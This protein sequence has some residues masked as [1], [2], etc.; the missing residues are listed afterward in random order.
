M[1]LSA[2]EANLLTGSIALGT[3]RVS[4]QVSGVLAAFEPT[5]LGE[6]AQ[7][8]LMDRAELKYLLPQAMLPSILAELRHSYRALTITG[9]PVGRYRTLYFDTPDM[10]LYMRHHAGVSDR[11]KIRSREYVDSHAAFFEVKHR[12]PNRRT[13]KRRI[14]T[15]GLLAT[16][17]GAVAEFLAEA[18]PYSA[19][20]LRAT[21]WN[22]YTRATLVGKTRAERVTF[23]LDLEYAWADASVALPGI[24][25]AEVKYDAAAGTGA[26]W[27]SPFVMAMRKRGLR[28]TTF[29]KYCIGLSLVC[30]NVK[31]NRFKPEHLAIERT[32]AAQRLIRGGEDARR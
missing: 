23:D 24:V 9:W 12:L 32:I 18:S 4:S 27:G 6:I 10:A 7:S 11:Y 17:G 30:P 16:P 25:I 15:A 20:E 1:T 3:M 2:V 26:A 8:A 31:H 5:S 13:Q 19:T 14:A 21:L 22:R 29:S 28:D